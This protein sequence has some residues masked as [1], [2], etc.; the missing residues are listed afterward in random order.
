MYTQ[1]NTCFVVGGVLGLE[2]TEAVA[3]IYEVL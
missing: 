3:R 2:A 1:Y